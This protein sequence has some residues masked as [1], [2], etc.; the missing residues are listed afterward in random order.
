MIVGA[1]Y[2]GLWTAYYLKAA[3]PSLCVLV[4]EREHAGF[5]ASGRNGGWVSGF[6]SGPARVYERRGGSAGFM[7]LQRAMFAT[8]DEVGRFLAEHGVQADFRKGGQVTAALDEAQALRLREWVRAERA[9]GYSEED[10]RELDAAAVAR[11]LRIQGARA[12]SYSPHVARVHPVKLLLGLAAAAE[13]LGVVIHERTPVL[14]LAAHEAR[15][16]AGAVRARWVVRACEGYTPQLRGMRRALAPVN[17]SMIITEPLPAGAWA[18]IGW[19]GA[20]LLGDGAHVYCYAQRTADGR[21][22]LGGRGVPYRVG[23]ASGG[24]GAT[25]ARTIAQLT[26][27]LHAMFPAAAGARVEH[28]WS[29]VLGVPRDWC[30][31]VQADPRSGL[32]WAGGYVGLGVAAANLAARTLRDVILE[33]PSELTALPW[34]GRAPRRWEPE[35]LRWAEINGLYALYRRADRS[36]RRRGRPSRLAELLDRASGRE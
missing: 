24:S 13:R 3:E 30:V 19:D 26:D 22:A 32:A 2:T 25:P 20:E 35:P 31:S 23:S 10:L 17:S 29:G 9:R 21:I 7:A 27:T 28:A 15:T 4:L 34:V 16:A 36:E 6:F 1:G 14:E 8:V 11:R 33:R 12:G 18:Q 5:G